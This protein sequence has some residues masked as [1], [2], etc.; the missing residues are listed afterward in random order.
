MQSHFHLDLSVTPTAPLSRHPCHQKTRQDM[1][2][3][4]NVLWQQLYMFPWC[5]VLFHM[6]LSPKMLM[7]PFD[8]ANIR[9]PFC[10]VKKVSFVNVAPYCS[11][12]Q[13]LSMWLYSEITRIQFDN[14]MLCKR[15]NMKITWIFPWLIL[16]LNNDFLARFVDK[17]KTASP[18]LL[19]EDSG[20]AL[21][22][23]R[24]SSLVS[25]IHSRG[26]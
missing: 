17:V 18:S 7:S 10:K 23:I 20:L 26:R 24:Q 15:S 12:W 8:K 16:L 21:N 19:L 1:T 2:E 4:D 3:T 5:D 14:L 11:I 6:P 9:V 25:H 22:H 13:M